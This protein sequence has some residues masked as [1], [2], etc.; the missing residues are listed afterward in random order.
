MAVVILPTTLERQAV[1]V[2]QVL[3]APQE[4]HLLLWEQAAIQ[5]SRVQPQAIHWVAVGRKESQ[6]AVAL[7]VMWVM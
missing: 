7:G 3:L 2:G 4:G 5:L 1:A 6:E